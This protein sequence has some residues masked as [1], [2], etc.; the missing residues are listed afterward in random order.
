[1]DVIFAGVGGQGSILVSHL[2]AD[3]ALASGHKVRLTETFGA[4]TRG[5]SVFS[6]VRIGE[7]WAPLPGEDQA[8]VVI[9]LEPLEGLRVALKFLAPDGW[10]LL[11][12]RPWYPVDVSVGR[13]T[14]PGIRQL[15]A[16]SQ[17]LGLMALDLLALEDE[18]IFAQME[19]RWSEK[20]VS[21][22]MEAYRRGKECFREHILASA[23][24]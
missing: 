17:R 10:V 4:A 11:N 9:G 13:A 24:L 1:M 23:G 21:A 20:L 15:I 5:G 16:A 19:K 22:N 7:A 8:Q 14:Y 3:T 18:R 2:L 12:T 6:C